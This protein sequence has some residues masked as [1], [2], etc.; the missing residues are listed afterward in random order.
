MY[1]G[2]GD[3][4]RGSCGEEVSAQY[5][6]RHR[7][8]GHDQFFCRVEN[9]ISQGRDACFECGEDGGEPGAEDAGR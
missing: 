8:G 7:D 4:G 5:E 6:E 3:F 1:S 2:D 9:A